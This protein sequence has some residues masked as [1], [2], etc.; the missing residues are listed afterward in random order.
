M[1]K[2][3][4]CYG[5]SNTWGYNPATKERYAEEIRWAGI[6]PKLLGDGYAVIAEG[7]NGRTTV[8]DDPIEE[9]RNGKT[10]LG[11]CLQTH[12]PIHLVVLLLGT[13]DMKKRFSASAFDIA[14]GAGRLLEIIRTSAAGPGGRPPKLLLLA[15]PPVARLTEYAEMFEGAEEKSRLLGRYYRDQAALY[16]AEF[17]NTADVIV[18][19]DVDGIHLD[20]AEH[21]KLASAVARRV[22]EIE[23]QA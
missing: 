3:V 20:P 12:A 11:P 9:G 15:P 6:L 19:S 22:R 2:T 5:D 17:L 21:S 4:L 1:R 14:R 10:Y 16:G 23:P 18:S 13:N 8:W 7:L